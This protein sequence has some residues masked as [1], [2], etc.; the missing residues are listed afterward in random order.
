[1][2]CTQNTSNTS[3]VK[4]SYTSDGQYTATYRGRPVG[5]EASPRTVTNGSLTPWAPKGVLTSWISPT[6][7]LEGL[8]AGTGKKLT[9]GDAEEG[10]FSEPIVNEYS[11]ATESFTAPLGAYSETLSGAGEMGI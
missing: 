7:H 10:V 2:G 1:M 9:V 8:R 5:V 11:P 4:V 3:V 6:G